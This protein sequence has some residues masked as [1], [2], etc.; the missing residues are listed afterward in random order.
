MKSVLCVECVSVF[1]WEPFSFKLNFRRPDWLVWLPSFQQH[2]TCLVLRVC[3]CRKLSGPSNVVRVVVLLV[4]VLV[5]LA[6]VLVL[7]LVSMWLRDLMNHFKHSAH[8]GRHH[9]LSQPTNLGF[10]SP[11]SNV[12]CYHRSNP[13]GVF[14]FCFWT[15]SPFV[16]RTNGGGD[17]WWWLPF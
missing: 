1:R 5:L 11:G 16:V 6:L 13:L 17:V 9:P 14:C 15:S 8:G 3:V 7:V 4:L 2:R 10:L 12:G